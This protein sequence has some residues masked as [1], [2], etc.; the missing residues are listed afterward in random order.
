MK[1]S[2]PN[3]DDSMLLTNLFEQDSKDIQK[4]IQNIESG[5]TNSEVI[6]SLKKIQENPEKEASLT[7]IEKKMNLKNGFHCFEEKESRG[8]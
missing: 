6:T 2:S 1:T 4:E 7:A 8:Y 3:F 5:M